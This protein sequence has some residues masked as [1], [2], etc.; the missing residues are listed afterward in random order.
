MGLGEIASLEF[1]SR[2]T[3]MTVARPKRCLQRAVLPREVWT[4]VL[5]ECCRSSR[6]RG[7]CAER[8]YLRSVWDEFDRFVAGTPIFWSEVRVDLFTGVESLLAAIASSKG[9]ALHLIVDLRSDLAEWEIDTELDGDPHQVKLLQCLDVVRSVSFKW[10]TVCCQV[11]REL[12]LEV[13]RDFLESSP[14]PMLTCLDIESTVVDL[15]P[16]VRVFKDTLPSL[17]QLRIVAFPFV[18]IRDATFG[19]LATLELRAISPLH[20]TSVSVFAALLEGLSVT[21]ES[22]VLAGMGFSVHGLDQHAPFAMPLLENLEIVFGYG[23]PMQDN[24]V[25]TMLAGIDFPSLR[26]LKIE[27]AGDEAVAHL[28]TAVPFLRNVIN[29]VVVGGLMGRTSIDCLLR[30]V[31]GLSSLDLRAAPYEFAE[32]LAALPDVLPNVVALR[33][34]A[35]DTSSVLTYVLVRDALG[36]PPIERL[37]GVQEAVSPLTPSQIVAVEELSKIG[38]IFVDASLESSLHRSIVSGSA[39]T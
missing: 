21:L 14:A 1:V 30:A 6:A 10:R 3:F 33:F 17:R 16:R 22:L 2:W 15:Q 34:D 20:F 35:L 37:Y 31:P 27:N 7:F 24:A 18:W 25:M 36:L 26:S 4:L 38:G 32:E 11:D 29:L 23:S 5:L 8:D 19:S 28:A 12:Y 9:I 39:R 13:A